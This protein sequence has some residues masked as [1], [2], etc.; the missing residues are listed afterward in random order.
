MRKI[1]F[2]IFFIVFE[3]TQYLDL[4]FTRLAL[5]NLMN[6]E[7]NPLYT[8]DSFIAIKLLMPVFITVCF[9]IYHYKYN[10]H[11]DLLITH[12]MKFI[13]GMYCFVIINNIII[14]R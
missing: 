9:L 4:F 3:I 10:K 8:H 1:Y 12:A 13:I 5:R 7:L 2:L 14:M 6:H 11:Y